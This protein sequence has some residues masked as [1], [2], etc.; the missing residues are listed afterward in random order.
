[1]CYQVL[2][3]THASSDSQ[4]RQSTLHSYPCC[5]AWCGTAALKPRH[6]HDLSDRWGWGGIYTHPLP[7][8]RLSSS[9]RFSHA[10]TEKELSL[11]PSIVDLN[12]PSK[13]ID[14]PINPWWKRVQNSIREQVHWFP[15]S[16]EHLIHVLAGGC[17]CYSWS[18]A[19][20]R[21]ERRPWSLPTYVAAL[22]GL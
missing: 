22:G 3:H 7:P 2:K 11:S 21:L 14:F 5:L 19:P 6:C 13:S 16:K 15:N 12:P 17:V 20:S 1:M 18:L 4:P 9:C 10:Q 8:Q